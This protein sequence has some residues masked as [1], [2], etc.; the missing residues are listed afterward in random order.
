MKVLTG[1]QI[2]EPQKHLIDRYGGIHGIRDKG[3]LDSALNAPFQTFSGSEL[4]PDIIEKAARLGYGL[5]KG[6]A[7]IDGNKR[8]GTHAMLIF[9]LLNDIELVYSDVD[10]IKMILDVAA[11]T[12]DCKKLSEWLINHKKQ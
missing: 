7:F 10:L 11:G 5:I 9:L 12:A 4:Y 2:I 1:K 8:I 6:H 3:I